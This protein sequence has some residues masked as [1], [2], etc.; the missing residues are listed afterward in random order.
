MR[1]AGVALLLLAAAGCASAGPTTRLAWDNMA[2]CK[3]CNCL[4]LADADPAAK[5][6]VCNCGFANHQCMSKRPAT[7]CPLRREAKAQ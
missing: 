7:S 1:R 5:C 4:M 6:N 2:T 3:H